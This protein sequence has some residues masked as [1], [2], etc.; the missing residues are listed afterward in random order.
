M[1]TSDFVFER[2]E[3]VP[4]GSN[5]ETDYVFV[6][7]D[8]VPNTGVSELVFESGV[9]VGGVS[10]YG[11]VL[12]NIDDGTET[13][14]EL[15]KEDFSVIRSYGYSGTRDGIG[16]HAGVLYAS[17]RGPPKAEEREPSDFSQIRVAGVP[18]DAEGIGGDTERIW[19]IAS[20][21]GERLYE[22]DV[23]DFS[24]IQD[25]EVGISNIEGCGGKRDVIWFSG[26]SNGEL[27]EADTTDLSVI[28]QTGTGYGSV[29]G[30]GGAP[31]VGWFASRDTSKNYEFDPSDLSVIKSG[32]SPDKNF[33]RGIGGA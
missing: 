26:Y 19:Y 27:A 10:E 12:W 18:G 9:G 2:G 11:P 25:R 31:D 23:A 24:V 16:G 30:T 17:Q 7:D 32:G 1:S 33:E 5:G 6:S 13:M 20:G 14:F 21:N 22:L 15:D 28:R 4:I 29:D 3:R 8:P